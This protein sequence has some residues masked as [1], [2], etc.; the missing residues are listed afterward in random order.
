MHA[1]MSSYHEL[2]TPHITYFLK[3]H[4]PSNTD[5]QFRKKRKVDVSKLKDDIE[6][7]RDDDIEER[8]DDD[9]EERRAKKLL[10]QQTP[11]LNKVVGSCVYDLQSTTQGLGTVLRLFDMYPFLHNEKYD[12]IVHEKGYYVNRPDK[13]SIMGVSGLSLLHTVAKCLDVNYKSHVCISTGAR[14]NRTA[15]NIIAELNR[16][17]ESVYHQCM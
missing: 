6:E 5:V 4:S 12:Y 9:I 16:H 13:T 15:E 10:R 17:Y 11:Y 3:M 8:R 14:M 2:P 7:R 1:D